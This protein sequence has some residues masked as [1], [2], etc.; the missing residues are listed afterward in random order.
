[1]LCAMCC[2]CH[3]LSAMCFPLLQVWVEVLKILEDTVSAVKLDAR[4]LILVL[5]YTVLS[6]PYVVCYV[7]C[8]MCIPLLLVCDKRA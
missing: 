7:L 1:M 6:V 2:V 5:Q 4:D 3:M 8:A